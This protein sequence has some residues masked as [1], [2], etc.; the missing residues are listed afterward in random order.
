MRNR[1]SLA[2]LTLALLIGL[3]V[4]SGQRA[5]AAS[6]DL[7]ARMQQV[8]A[9]LRSYRADVTVAIQLHSFP[10][11]SPTLAGTAYYKRPDKTAVDFQSVPAL[12]GQLKKVVGQIE[13]PDEWPSLYVVTP[14]GDDG[15]TASFRLVRKK[16]GRI[17]HV[18]VQV[19]D[20]TATVSAMTYYYKDD[21]GTI[22]F[23][24]SYDDIDGNYVIAQQTGKVDIP[25]Y[26]ADVTSR[27]TNY[28]V[29]VDVPD[30]VFK[31]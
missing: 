14:T 11:I 5:S 27:F 20:K 7:Y 9:G 6:D 10:F 18:D 3:P 28:K 4:G 23:R 19:D 16:N 12:A 2:V 1:R 26:N 8:N 31:D 24:Q 22:A 13:P 21:G 15:A 29:N 17:D 25:H 30:A